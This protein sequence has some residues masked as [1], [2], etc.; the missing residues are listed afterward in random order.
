MIFSPYSVEDKTY[1]NIGKQRR[2]DNNIN[3]L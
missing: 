3:Y 1:R 2:L